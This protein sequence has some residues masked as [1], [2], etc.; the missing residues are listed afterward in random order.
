MNQNERE[1]LWMAYL[2]G[3]MSAAEASAF[4]ESL[5]AEEREQLAAEMRLEAGIAERLAAKVA[6]PDATWEALRSQLEGKPATV[7]T[8]VVRLPLRSLGLIAAAAAVVLVF[9]SV[10]GGDTVDSAPTSGS[11]DSAVSVAE[12][13]NMAHGVGVEEYFTQHNIQLAVADFSES[14]GHSHHK[15]IR[16]IGACDG[17][18]PYGSLYEVLFECCGEPVRVVLAEQSSRGA[19]MIKQAQAHGKVQATRMIGGYLAGVVGIHHAE[20]LLDLIEAKPAQVT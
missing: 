2:D 18:C 14:H 8:N 19:R 16:A 20:E 3:Q 9:Y 17:D 7:P 4:D 13:E 10:R 6:C 12:L 1:K 5:T 15:T 11:F